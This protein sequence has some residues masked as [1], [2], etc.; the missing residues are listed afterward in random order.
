MGFSNVWCSKH[1]FKP[2]TTIVQSKLETKTEFRQATI[3]FNL[4]FSPQLVH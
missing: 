1:T 2:M 3:L 4:R